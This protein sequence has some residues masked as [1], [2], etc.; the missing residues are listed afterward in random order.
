MRSGGRAAGRERA[1]PSPSD[2][3]P[4]TLDPD[5]DRL[6][7]RGRHRL[8]VTTTGRRARGRARCARRAAPR[9]QAGKRAV[10]F[11]K[12]RAQF[13]GARLCATPRIFLQVKLRQIQPPQDRTTASYERWCRQGNIVFVGQI[14]TKGNRES[15]RMPALRPLCGVRERFRGHAFEGE[16]DRHRSQDEQHPERSPSGT[17]D[18]REMHAAPAF[19]TRS[20]VLQNKVLCARIRCGPDGTSVVSRSPCRRMASLF[21]RRSRQR[22]RE[23]RRPP[24]IPG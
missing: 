16:I 6:L 3:L 4:R 2:G 12:L 8:P 7:L 24:A 13:S 11:R 20:C 5:A 9:P 17:V 18:R 15:G 14:L 23:S 10:D 21:P 22:L 19:N 1:T